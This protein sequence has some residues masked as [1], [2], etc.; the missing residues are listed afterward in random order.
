MGQ[1]W[2]LLNLDKREIHSL[3]KLGEGLFEALGAVLD[4]LWRTLEFPDCDSIVRRYRPGE[5]LWPENKY[6][7]AI[8]FAKTAPRSPDATTL[9][10]LPAEIIHKIYECIDEFA[11]LL[12]LSITCQVLWE[13]GRGELYRRAMSYA[14][15]CCWAGDRIV[16]KGGY[17]LKD[18]IPETLLSAEERKELFVAE[19]EEREEHD[20]DEHED[21]DEDED[22]KECYIDI[23]ED[24][25]DGGNDLKTFSWQKIWFENGMYRCLC[26]PMEHAVVTELR[27]YD[28]PPPPTLCILRNLS[29]RQYVRE[30]ALFD[31]RDKYKGTNVEM[32]KVALGEVVLCRTCFS[33]SASTAL[34]YEGDIEVH[35]GVWAGDR[36]D[37]VSAE[38][39]KE[40]ESNVAGDWTD[41]SSEALKEVEDIWVAEYA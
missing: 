24:V 40:L 31:L 20:D 6:H 28:P 35:R 37:I 8:Y 33:S 3:G 7:G 18:D 36:F 39:L 34:R 14:A 30:S 13:I 22:E 27:K 5:L 17:L 2:Y 15:S 21:E 29:R 26:S 19:D 11:H 9:V 12:F 4:P 1:S 16:V 38:W 41:V 10:N 25:W 32:D 23:R